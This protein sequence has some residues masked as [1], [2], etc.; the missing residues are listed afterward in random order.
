M[1]FSCHKIGRALLIAGASLFVSC[2]E[3]RSG[4]PSLEACNGL[5]DDQDGV[6]DD[7]ATCE[8]LGTVLTAA[9]IEGDCRIL[10]CGEG[11]ADCDAFHGTGC[12]ADTQVDWGACG[13]CTPCS[14]YSACIE[15][16]CV[17]VA[18]RVLGGA[19]DQRVDEIVSLGGGNMAI[20]GDFE[21]ALWLGG[22]SIADEAHEHAF[23]WSFGSDFSHRFLSLVKAGADPSARLISAAG[24]DVG[25][26]G[27]LYVTGHFHDSITSGTSSL[28]RAGT[29]AWIGKLTESGGTEWLVAPEA[30]LMSGVTFSTAFDVL[31]AGPEV[32]FTGQYFATWTGAFAS[33]FDTDGAEL[34]VNDINPVGDAYAQHVIAYGQGTLVAGRFSGMLEHGARAAQT[35][36]GA[37]YVA[38]IDDAGGDASLLVTHDVSGAD[39]D[40]FG[41]VPIS[42]NGFVLGH[43]AGN[44]SWIRAYDGET[45]RWTLHTEGLHSARLAS[46]DGKVYFVASVEELG[47]VAIGA[48]SFSHRPSWSVVLAILD[49]TDG[50]LERAV[51]LT[52]AELVLT[53]GRPAIQAITVADDGTV[54]L[55]ING[56]GTVLGVPTLGQD[57]ALIGIDAAALD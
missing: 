14:A 31:A 29:R 53:E 21:H 5:D 20:A 10:A 4:S 47:D 49:D 57:F 28:A 25:S 56:T 32:R 54:W 45:P 35:S 41:L 36:D 51:Q 9:C 16:V 1:W 37:A 17:P 30:P 11:F 15:G 39:D 2:G 13:T 24:L 26:D 3:H 44:E 34:S 50:S 12:E 6:V 42:S 40:A 7:G 55:V 18:T 52:L 38:A 27:S 8:A 23:V 33:R 43:V 46:A 48:R 22:S 19:G